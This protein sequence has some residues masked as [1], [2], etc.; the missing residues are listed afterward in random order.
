MTIDDVVWEVRIGVVLVRQAELD[1][2]APRGMPIP[3]LP[4]GVACYR[5][6]EEALTLM[7]WLMRQYPDQQVSL[8]GGKSIARRDVADLETLE[9]EHE[10]IAHRQDL[11]E[12]ERAARSG[13]L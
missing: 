2:Q 6:A 7:R 11:L 9:H 12:R 1:R 13:R 8:V 4:G 10:P 3:R 5:D